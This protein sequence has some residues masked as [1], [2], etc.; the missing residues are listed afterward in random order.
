MIVERDFCSIMWELVKL[1]RK[2]VDSLGITGV[3]IIVYLRIE[4]N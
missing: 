2:K 3:H 1:D 4:E